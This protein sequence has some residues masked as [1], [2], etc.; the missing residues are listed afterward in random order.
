MRCSSIR[1]N[2]EEQRSIRDTGNGLRQRRPRSPAAAPTQID[3]DAAVA[4][5][6]D[7]VCN[8]DL[9]P[10]LQ[11]G[12]RYSADHAKARKFPGKPH[13][14]LRVQLTAG[15]SKWP[16]Q[17]TAF[18]DSRAYRRLTRITRRAGRAARSLPERRSAKFR[19]ADSIC[20]SK[21]AAARKRPDW[22]R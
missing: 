6:A 11:H 5:Y 2:R 22:E 1:R 17:A 10:P 3:A 4:D 14:G 21:V 20:W 16:S 7:D 8:F 15:R 19:R 13:S 12:L 18:V 9:A